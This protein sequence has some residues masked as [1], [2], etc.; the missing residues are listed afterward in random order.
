MQSILQAIDSNQV[1]VISGSTGVGTTTQVPQFILDASTLRR[2]GGWCNI[3]CAVPGKDGTIR[4]A[5]R[6]AEERVEP[7]GQSVGYE[8]GNKSKRSEM[9]RLLFCTI[10]ILRRRLEN[11]T[12]PRGTSHVVVDEV[13]KRLHELD[14]L[15]R[16]LR[17]L[18]QSRPDVKVV[19]LMSATIN[20]EMFS[21]YFGKCPVLEI[22]D[23]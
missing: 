10:D 9:T 19:F 20:E 7:L 21:D 15:L 12:L 8:I 3:V 2:E 17:D 22:P 5:T 1:V 6:V 11:D 4:A 14:S 18:M 23:R 13:H 16:A